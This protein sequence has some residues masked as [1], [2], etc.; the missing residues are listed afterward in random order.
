[1]EAKKET[2]WCS[3]VFCKGLIISLQVIL[4]LC[5]ACVMI[6]YD[7]NNRMIEDFKTEINSMKKAIDGLKKTVTQNDERSSRTKR[8]ISNVDNLFKA[9]DQRIKS[10]EYRYIVVF[11]F[12][13]K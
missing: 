12:Q 3:Q 10:L 1:M 8:S 9:Y 11:Q 6:S 2:N 13:L 4:L 7:V 5:A